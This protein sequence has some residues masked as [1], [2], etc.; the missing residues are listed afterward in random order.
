VLGI[1]GKGKGSKGLLVGLG[2]DGFASPRL[3]SLK[4]IQ[5]S[6]TF[7]HTERITA[8]YYIRRFD[9]R[10]KNR[11]ENSTQYTHGMAGKKNQTTTNGVVKKFSK[12]LKRKLLFKSKQHGK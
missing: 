4:V 10:R 1:F 8:L 6:L 7:S 2:S 11:P 9:V 3:L 12:N 5:H